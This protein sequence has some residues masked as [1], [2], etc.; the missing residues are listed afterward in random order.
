[1]YIIN[2]TTSNHEGL[3]IKEIQFF[4]N[5]GKTCHAHGNAVIIDLKNFTINILPFFDLINANFGGDYTKGVSPESHINLGCSIEYFFYKKRREIKSGGCYEAIRNNSIFASNTLHT[6]FVRPNGFIISNGKLISKPEKYDAMGLDC[7]KFQRLNG[8]YS[9]MGLSHENVK[10]HE[11]VFEDG[12]IKTPTKLPIMGISGPILVQNSTNISHNIPFRPA[13]DS[14]YPYGLK[15]YASNNPKYLK[16]PPGPTLGNEINFPPPSTMTSFSAFGV[17]N[18][19][20]LIAVSI[21][22]NLS[23][24]ND[25][26]KGGINIYELAEL[27]ITHLHAKDAILAGGGADTQQFIQGH[28]EEIFLA[29]KRKRSPGQPIRDEVYG[30][31]GLG[32]IF[33]I[34]KKRTSP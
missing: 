9:L 32:A 27:L 26:I 14:K 21:L 30:T 25:S 10:F 29:K 33:T 8:K 1:M 19:N 13:P 34:S 15:K 23:S 3:E 16:V 20:R 24:G 31:R 11:L 2:N 12:V 7:P 6:N 4:R 18:D 22:D 17:H 28:K 5:N